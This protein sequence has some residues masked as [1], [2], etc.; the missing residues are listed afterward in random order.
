MNLLEFKL[1]VLKPGKLKLLI[2]FWIRKLLKWLE[3]HIKS[4]GKSHS[5]QSNK[6]ESFVNTLQTGGEIQRVSMMN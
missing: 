2:I 6:N 4:L 3:A 5:T 1:N